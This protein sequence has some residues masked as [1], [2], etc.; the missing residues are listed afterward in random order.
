MAILDDLAYQY[1]SDKTPR[2]K[3]HYTAYYEQLFEPMRDSVRKVLEIGI[4][5][6]LEMAWSSAPQYHT[7]AS[8]R[9]WRDYFPNAQVFGMDIK[10]LRLDEPRISI[11]QGDQASS[12]DLE[13]LLELTGTDLDIVI[14]DA[15]HIAEHQVFTCKTL[16]PRLKAGVVYVIEDVGH[17]EIA[18]QLS[19]YEVKAYR[20]G[21]Q[22]SHDDR[23]LIVRH[24]GQG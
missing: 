7:G 23:L 5:D 21:K 8:L 15:S 19:E 22:S 14:E 17:P 6:A 20:P 10:W 24:R 12:A 2:I 9:M 13:R 1:G 3:H 11:T 16:M 4:G 18:E